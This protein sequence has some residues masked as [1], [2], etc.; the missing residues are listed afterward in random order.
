MFKRYGS[1]GH[2]DLSAMWLCLAVLVVIAFI[3]A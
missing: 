3:F 1:D 2:Y